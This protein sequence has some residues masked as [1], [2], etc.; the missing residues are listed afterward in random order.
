M[1]VREEGLLGDENDLND[2][3]EVLMK[4]ARIEVVNPETG[5]RN[6]ATVLLDTGAKHSYI[7]SELASTIGLRG[8]KSHLVRLNTFGTKKQT[9]MLT[10]LTSLSILQKDGL[11]IN[12]NARICNT[13]TGTVMRKR[14]PMKKYENICR[15]LVMADKIS[16]SDSRS[17]LYEDFF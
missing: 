8:R 10:Q 15:D 14:L 11:Y 12:I 1:V 5:K 7:S 6:Y 13:I 4:T 9:D 3:Y 2:H 17:G 16:D